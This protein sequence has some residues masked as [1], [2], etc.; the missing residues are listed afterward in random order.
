VRCRCKFIEVSAVFNHKIDDLLVGILKQI[1]L[2]HLVCTVFRKISGPDDG[3]HHHRQQ[4]KGK[5][6]SRRGR[7]L[8]RA[9]G[10][11]STDETTGAGCAALTGARELV[12]RLFGSVGG[13][14]R[15]RSCDNLLVL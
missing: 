14:H 12:G 13:R 8:M 4:E 9:E 7:G 1:Q 10:G 6:Q 15:S 3:H 11:G 2:K 5:L